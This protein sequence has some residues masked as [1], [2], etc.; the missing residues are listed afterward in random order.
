MKNV[1]RI[2]AFLFS[3]LSLGFGSSV[4]A[5]DCLSDWAALQETTNA[6][7]VDLLPGLIYTLCPNTFFRA[8]G[9]IRFRVDATVE[10][11]YHGSGDDCIIEP[12]N[13]RSSFF[14]VASAYHEVQPYVTFVGLT[15]REY[16]TAVTVA[17]YDEN[18]DY[19]VYEYKGD[20]TFIDCAF[21]DTSGPYCVGVRGDCA[22]SLT[23]LRCTFAGQN[24][25]GIYTG[26]SGNTVCGLYGSLT[27]EDCIFEENKGG[28]LFSGRGAL[29][30]NNSC[31]LS[32][33]QEGPYGGFEDITLLDWRTT[34]SSFENNFSD[35]AG[36][37]ANGRLV[38][39]SPSCDLRAPS[40]VPT[41][42]PTASSAPS[43]GPSFEPSAPPSNQPSFTPSSSPSLSQTPSSWPSSIPSNSVGPSVLPTSESS[44]EPSSV[45]SNQP[46]RI[47][48]LNPSARPT[49]LPSGP[50]SQ[51]P[52][53][54]SSIPPSFIPSSAP[55]S[56]SPSSHPSSSPSSLPSSNPSL[57]SEIDGKESNSGTAEPSIAP[58][59]PASSSVHPDLSGMVASCFS[60]VAALMLAVGV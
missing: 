50:P 13:G 14:L 1:M 7:S 20:A 26:D 27:V 57:S 59:S 15:M 19:N 46:S 40:S 28:I 41:V 47:P 49:V 11:G 31:F 21:Q 18:P 39:Q 55:T 12:A 16:G 35:G 30:I 51:L 29:S 53:F 25:P 4:E 3:V 22:P 43:S 37:N 6:N 2:A 9:Q 60:I 42:M 48:S 5:Q 56:E 54:T 33:I 44:L 23:F 52:S 38:F 34:A 36:S 24:Y 10:C 17:G 8:S 45:P 32:N 58:N